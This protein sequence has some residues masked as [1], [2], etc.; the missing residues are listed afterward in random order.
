MLVFPTLSKLLAQLSPCQQELTVLRK[1]LHSEQGHRYALHE[2]GKV[3]RVN[4]SRTKDSEPKEIYFEPLLFKE[5]PPKAGPLS[6]C[7]LFRT[8]GQAGLTTQSQQIVLQLVNS[9]NIYLLSSTRQSHDVTFSSFV[10]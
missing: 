10:G 9:T 4:G 2:L 5:N 8:S 1:M 7:F 3:A 6:A